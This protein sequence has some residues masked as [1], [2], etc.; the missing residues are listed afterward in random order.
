[1][2]DGPTGTKVPLKLGKKIV[3]Y[4]SHTVLAR[5]LKKIFHLAPIFYAAVL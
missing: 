1:M 2:T 3:I 4:G 5:Y